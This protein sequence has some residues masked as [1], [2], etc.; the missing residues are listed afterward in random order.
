MG[1][2][3]N[4]RFVLS[5]LGEFCDGLEPESVR[6]ILLADVLSSMTPAAQ[7]LLLDGIARVLEPGGRLAFAIVHPLNS[8]GKF[9][10]KT[11]DSPF[12][13]R[14]SYLDAFR[15]ADHV[16]R[17]GLSMTFHSEHRPLEV[18]F[19]ALSEAGFVVEA[20]RE[21][22]VPDEALRNA[23]SRRWQRVP[24]FLHVRARRP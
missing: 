16:E 17:D 3:P 20:L 8:A 11:E 14:G 10:S 21:P 23:R 24:L 4:L 6:G 5:D 13:I 2:L 12:V 9:A 22:R 15:Y 1:N 19:H 18:Y 7:D